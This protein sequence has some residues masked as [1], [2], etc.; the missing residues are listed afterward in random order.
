MREYS[1]RWSH[2]VGERGEFVERSEA[3]RELVGMKGDK[4]RGK[5]SR[6]PQINRR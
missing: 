3:G 6:L 1:Q 4:E 5:L 2:V